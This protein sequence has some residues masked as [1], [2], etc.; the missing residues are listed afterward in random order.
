MAIYI[1]FHDLKSQYYIQI[2]YF[3]K[4]INEIK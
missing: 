2:K 4:T 3:I 1:Q